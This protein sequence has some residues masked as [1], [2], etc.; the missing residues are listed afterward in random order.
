MVTLIKKDWAA[1]LIADKL[2][3]RDK[4]RHYV[5]KCYVQK[6]ITNLSMYMPNN[7]ASKY[8]KQNW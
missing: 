4:D 5:K 1:I 7:G 3:F 2:D 6:D 8:W